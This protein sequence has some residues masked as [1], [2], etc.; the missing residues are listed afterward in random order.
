VFACIIFLLGLWKAQ[1]RS[2]VSFAPEVENELPD[3]LNSA[4]PTTDQRPFI[5]RVDASLGQFF[6][7][8]SQSGHSHP[9]GVQH[10]QTG[11]GHSHQF[12]VQNS[13]SGSWRGPQHNHV[14]NRPYGWNP[15]GQWQNQHQ[16]YRPWNPQNRYSPPAQQN[17]PNKPNQPEA[18][19]PQTPSAAPSSQNPNLSASSQNPNI[20]ETSAPQVPNKAGT[21]LPNTQ[22]QT[23]EQH[24][25]PP[26]LPNKPWWQRA[27]APWSLQKSASI[28]NKLVPYTNLP[29]NKSPSPGIPNKA[30][31]H[32]PYYP[33]P[34]FNMQPSPLESTPDLA[35]RLPKEECISYKGELGECSSYQQCG[36]QGGVPSGLCHL[37]HD[38]SAHARTCCIFPSFCGYET[39]KD[40][41]YFKNPNYPNTTSSLNN[42]LYR[43]NL[44]PGVCQ[45]RVDFL[46]LSMKP[47]VHGECDP[48]NSLR[49]SSND[50]HAYI[51]L[52][53]FCGTVAEDVVDPL[54]TD[55]PHMYVHVDD[56][57]ALD[58]PSFQVP[59]HKQKSV[60]F[61]FKVTD[62]L[63]RWNLRISQIQC[64]GA[65]LQASQG[66]SQFYTQNKGN[67]TSFNM[68]DNSYPNS[69]DMSV[70]I[71]RDP[72]ACA[73]HY[74]LKTFGVGP[75]KGSRDG[76]QSMGYG[77]ICHDYVVFNGEK[78]CICGGINNAKDIILPVKG[79]QGFT[80]RSDASHIPLADVGYHMEYEYLHN[81]TGTVF[82]KYPS[83]V[84]N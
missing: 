37:G 67:I 65:N 68:A 64:D 41:T 4:S 52:E 22:F 73:I 5:D 38:V 40:V 25:R 75:T 59:N 48:S 2:L 82:Y 44:L 32:V 72:S 19:S 12:G 18:A 60:T 78:T 46:D 13:Q 11:G 71:L 79:P 21:S 58:R 33:H 30:P 45:V 70:C 62:Y 29:P 50:R 28:P 49:I 47:M 10:P 55:I 61:R 35:S 66:C 34:P 42:C 56:D 3:S 51:P 27:P 80:V 39:N 54:R 1:G 84:K 16:N 43:V 63:T 15:Q 76:K 24:P 74:K 14:P 8:S 26:F 36:H 83:A 53:N 57:L 9:G 23:N 81:C 20:P 69:M 7:D 6:G 77:L 17:F 31:A